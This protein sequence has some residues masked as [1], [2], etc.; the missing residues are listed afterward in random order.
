MRGAAARVNA[1]PVKTAPASV[2]IVAPGG[3]LSFTDSHSPAVPSSATSATVAACH[4][5]SRLV[6][7]RT[8]AAGTTTS[9][10]TSSAPSAVS[11]DGHHQRDEREEHGV[12]RCAPHSQRSRGARIEA[13]R[14]PCATEQQGGS[15]CGG[16]CPAGDRQVARLDQQQAAEQQRLDAGPRREHVACEDHPQR[17]HAGERER[18]RDVRAEAVAPSERGDHQ[19]ERACGRERA[20]RGGKA[21]AVGEHQSRERGG[22][23]GVGV[24]GQA[25]QHDPAAEHAG[26]RGEQQHLRQAA[27]DV[28]QLERRGQGVHAARY[29]R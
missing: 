22:A 1:A 17:Q 16:A 3:A 12:D 2:A 9:A 21:Q 6:H 11:A 27:L 26:A 24:K 25:P 10:E 18:S 29:I 23:D 4:E 15:H 8:V 19:R 20:Q 13:A 5:G 28:G 14:Q 7:R